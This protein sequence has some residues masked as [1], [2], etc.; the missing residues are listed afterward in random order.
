[1]LNFMSYISGESVDSQEEETQG[2]GMLF[3]FG[4]KGKISRVFKKKPRGVTFC[5]V[6]L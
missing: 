6:L 5:F 1:M 2:S 4:F 3:A